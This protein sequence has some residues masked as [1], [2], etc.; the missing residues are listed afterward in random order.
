MDKPF[1]VVRDLSVEFVRGEPA[2]KQISFEVEEGAS[3]G[4]LGKSGAG[5]S[6]LMNSIR[7]T[8][9]HEPLTGKI[10]YN[11]AVCPNCNWI[12]YPSQAGKECEKC[13]STLEFR[14]ID[15]WEE[16]KNLTEVSFSLYNRISI[17]FQRTFGIFGELPVITNIQKILKNINYP[18]KLINKRALQLLS[19]VRL[20][21]RAMHLARDLSGGEKQRA[22]FAMCLARDPLLFIADEPSGTLDPV[23]AITVHD[24]MKNS[25]KEKGLT[26]LITS[27]W[28]KAVAELSES[29][30][31][32]DMGEMDSIGDSDEIA[33]QFLDKMEDVE[34]DRRTCTNP[35][36]QIN[37]CNKTYYTHDRG[38]VKA[39]NSVSFNVNEGEIFGLVGV[40]G[41]GKT[42]LVQMMIGEKKIT[43]GKILVKIGEEWVNMSVPGPEERGRA[44]KYMEILHQEYCLH[45]HLTILDN[46]IGAIEQQMPEEMKTKKAYDALRAV[47]FNNKE[48]DSLIYKFP[49]SI[50][51]GERHR[52]A[53]ARVLIKEP[54]MVV[55]DEPTGTADPLTRLEIVQSIKKAREDLQQTY[56]IISH[57]IDFMK[58]VCDRCALM[59]QGIIEKI[60]DPDVVID[61]FKELESKKDIY[62]H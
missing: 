11:V 2:I 39:V 27:H 4:I 47:N 10:I 31:L 50:S 44:T 38:L 22:V 40:S 18:E 30:I 3:F 58:A 54:K 55:L 34:I 59:A 5:K 37:K 16:R 52:I 62:S 8:K 6:V 43:Q 49:D 42:S 26:L 17:M 45:P 1:L 61:Y 29:A 33:Q 19:D 53:I 60:G 14:E 41:A 15:Y 32:L 20:G 7:G 28:P 57:D 46:L 25:V 36:I 9:D 12:E 24:V 51:E 21:H 13:S 23:T 48:I 35:L 56:F